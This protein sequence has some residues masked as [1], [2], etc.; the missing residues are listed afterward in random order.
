MRV[1]L[2][3][4][5]EPQQS[6]PAQTGDERRTE[7][8]RKTDIT[9]RVYTVLAGLVRSE[10]EKRSEPSDLE[11]EGLCECM[12]CQEIREVLS[13]ALWRLQWMGRHGNDEQVGL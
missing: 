9:R 13:E 8:A 11:C 3:E 7:S 2:W 4:G 12:P 6:A 1:P 5:E 10:L